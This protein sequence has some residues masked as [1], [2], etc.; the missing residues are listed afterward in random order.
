MLYQHTLCPVLAAVSLFA[1]ESAERLP[2]HE[3]RNAL[4]PTLVYALVILL[5]NLC[6]VV[7]GPYP[8]L[9]VYAQ[10]WYASVLWCAVILGIAALLAWGVLTLHNYLGRKVIDG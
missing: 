9:M 7:E 2:R 8:F 6:R 4:I 10:P 3:I 5:L 1:W